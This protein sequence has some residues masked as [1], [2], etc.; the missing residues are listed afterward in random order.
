[1]ASEWCRLVV[2]ALKANKRWSTKALEFVVEMTSSRARNTPTSAATLS[3][4]GVAEEVDKDVVSLVCKGIRD[5]VGCVTEAL[6]GLRPVSPICAG[7]SDAF[8]CSVLTIE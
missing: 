6:T 5:F 1:M 8:R 7:W 4:S 3:V 2:V